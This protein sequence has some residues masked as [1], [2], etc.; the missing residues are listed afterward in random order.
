MKYRYLIALTATITSTA[1]AAMP[2]TRPEFK[3]LIVISYP[4]ALA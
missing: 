1:F 4:L 3:S 2:A